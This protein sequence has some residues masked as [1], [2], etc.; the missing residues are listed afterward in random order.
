MAV[1]ASS[2]AR[3]GT[4]AQITAGGLWID[5]GNADRIAPSLRS[6]F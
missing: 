1:R 3:A 5:T 4:P 2:G 6:G